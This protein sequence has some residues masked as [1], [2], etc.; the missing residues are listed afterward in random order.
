[1]DNTSEINALVQRIDDPDELIFNQVKDKI[2]NMGS[3]VI[4]H[5]EKAW[6][7][8]QL[9]DLFQSRLE[10]IIHDIHIKDVLK[11]LANWIG[12]NQH[13]IV[14]GGTNLG[15]MKVLIKEASKYDI[16]IYGITPS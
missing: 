16:R 13:N 15:L 5:L 4:P 14:F 8:E 2:M 11:K 9:G 3:N 7:K 1:M 12:K 6:A 10:N